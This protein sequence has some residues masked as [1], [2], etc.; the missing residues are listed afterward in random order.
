MIVMVYT[1]GSLISKH[2]LRH[3]FMI[4]KK[5][6]KFTEVGYTTTAG[7]YSRMALSQ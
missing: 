1:Q 5:N 7:L 4:K 2:F 3:L 6:L